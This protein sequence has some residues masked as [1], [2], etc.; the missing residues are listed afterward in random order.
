MCRMRN[1]TVINGEAA[2]P[3]AYQCTCHVLGQTHW[4]EQLTEVDV[5]N[6]PIGH[7]SHLPP[8]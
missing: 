1:L 3:A 6:E 2:S 8:P 4:D 7:E 5:T